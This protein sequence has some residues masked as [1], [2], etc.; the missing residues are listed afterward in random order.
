[1]W[2]IIGIG[3]I[4]DSESSKMVRIISGILQIELENF[5]PEGNIFFGIYCA[6]SCSTNRNEFNNNLSSE[7]IELCHLN[8]SDNNYTLQELSI[9]KNTIYA[10]HGYVF[11]TDFLKNHFSQFSWYIP[12]PFGSI[13]QFLR[14]DSG[15][16]HN[17][18]YRSV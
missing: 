18:E 5:N 11:K 4:I 14:E 8:L 6:K 3:K 7:M 16:L 12:Y 15:R 1:K 13:I 2:S 10:Q 9:L 17:Q